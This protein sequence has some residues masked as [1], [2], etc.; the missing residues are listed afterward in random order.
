MEG[1]GLAFGPLRVTC[2]EGT[3]T[4]YLAIDLGSTFLKGAVL[5]LDRCLCGETQ[6]VRTPASVAAAGSPFH[7][8][9]PDALCAAFTDLVGRLLAQAPDARGLVMCTQMHGMVLVDENGQAFGN[10]ITWQDQRGALAMP[11]EGGGSVVEWIADRLPA[12]LRVALGNELRPGIPAAT[13]LWMVRAGQ[14][15]DSG[16]SVVS[17]PDHVLSRLSGQ[18]AVIDPTNAAS[19]GMFDVRAGAWSAEAVALLGLEGFH[20]PPICADARAVPYTFSLHGVELQ[21]HVPVGDHQCALLGSMLQAGE[22][23]VNVATGSQ[24]STLSDTFHPGDCQVRPYPDG[25]FLHTITHIPA[26]RSLN[27]WMRLLTEMASAA[28][29]PVR[30]PWEIAG[31]LAAE[32]GSTDLEMDLSLFQNRVPRGGEAGALRNIREGNLTVGHLFRAALERMADDYFRHAS[33]LPAPPGGWRRLV[34]SGGIAHRL[35][36]LRDLIMGRFGIPGRTSPTREDTMPGLLTLALLGAGRAPCL[37]N[38]AEL[39]SRQA[40]LPA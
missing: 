20:L 38:A 32:T 30:E 9:S 40:R 19:C 6:R 24:V 37:A 17:L 25:A 21:C 4:K 8:I 11:G 28:G 16:L 29:T 35:P 33:A 13:L 1:R 34:F 36:L 22:L 26:G 5:D 2:W 27:A 3:M 14:V 12:D 39:V 23:S 10:A 18:P 7:E 15:P 31:R